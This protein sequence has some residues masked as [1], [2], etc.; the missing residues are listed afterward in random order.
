MKPAVSESLILLSSP[1]PTAFP[2]FEKHST[3]VN[4]YNL[5][6]SDSGMFENHKR[7]ADKNR[8]AERPKKA[9]L[10]R[11]E[12]RSE[13]VGYMRALSPRPLLLFNPQLHPA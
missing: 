1:I 13:G 8:P 7:T 6:S 11:I 4:P 3:S 5:L 12:A 2:A 10:G 9:V